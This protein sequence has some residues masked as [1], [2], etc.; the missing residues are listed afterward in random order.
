MLY[1]LTQPPNLVVKGVSGVLPVRN[2][3]LH[4]YI[5]PRR[6]VFFLIILSFPW[7]ANMSLCL[8]KS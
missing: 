6:V 1:V 4:I 5:T 3:S 7:L 8:L 2:T